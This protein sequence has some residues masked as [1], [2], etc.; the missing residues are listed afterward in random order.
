MMTASRTRNSRSAGGALAGTICTRAAMPV[1]PR[2][3]MTLSRPRL[4]PKCF[5]NWDSLVPASRAIATVLVFSYPLY[6][7]RRF[8]AMRIRSWDESGGM[9]FTLAVSGINIQSKE[10]DYVA[11]VV[12]VIIQRAG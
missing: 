9:D 6:A 8:A 3:R 1:Q 12:A 11:E 10:P 5:I 2:S 7:N 4:L